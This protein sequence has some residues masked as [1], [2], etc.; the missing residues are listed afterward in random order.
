VRSS[1]LRRLEVVA[2]VVVAA[3]AG[4]AIAV[5]AVSSGGGNPSGLP[6]TTLPTNPSSPTNPGMTRS[7]RS[8][9]DT[10]NGSTAGATVSEAQR[11]HAFAADLLV[12]GDNDP[13]RLVPASQLISLGQSVCQSHR[14]GVAKST[15]LSGLT[16]FNRQEAVLFYDTAIGKLC[17]R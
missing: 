14:S 9:T 5:V 16:A 15:I 17:P 11:E 13:F 7:T 2:A 12:L 3:T 10:T 1:R 4:V 8:T 6:A